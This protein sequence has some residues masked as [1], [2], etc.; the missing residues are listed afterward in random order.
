MAKEVFKNA[1]ILVNG[2]DLSPY[3]NRVAL[4]IMR[5]PKGATALD[6]A[7]WREYLASIL[8]ASWSVDGFYSAP[9]PDATLFAPSSSLVVMLSK[10]N[11]IAAGD[12]T[13]SLREVLKSY[14]PQ[15]T[16]GDVASFSA[17]AEATQAVAR[18]VCLEAFSGASNGS[19]AVRNLGATTSTQRVFAVLEVTSV[20]GGGATLN[21]V[22]ESDDADGFPSATTRV[23]FDQ[24][25]AVGAQWKEVVG[26]ITDTRW[27]TTRTISSG[28]FTYRV[29]LAIQ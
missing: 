2:V 5:E 12:V 22:G 1:T 27:R 26:P 9:E 10:T 24:V 18:G 21:V 3:S 20:P 13:W 23:T 19:S 17:S 15:F 6:S 25:T 28:T 29:S 14:A 7:G 4:E 16:V 8:S 11:P